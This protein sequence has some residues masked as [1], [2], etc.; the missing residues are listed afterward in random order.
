MSFT[1]GGKRPS[2]FPGLRLLID[3]QEPAMPDTRNRDL[4]VWG[5]HGDY[6]LGSFLGPRPFELK[7]AIVQ[8]NP[9]FLQDMV[10]QLTAFLVDGRGRPKTMDLVFDSE[11]GR[12]YRVRYS[13]SMGI[14]RL[15]G[16]GR[17]SL[18]M[19]AYDPFAYLVEDSDEIDV[20]SEIMVEET[21]TVDATYVYTITSSQTVDVDNFG[22]QNARPTIKL[23]GNFANLTITNGTKVLG[24][25]PAVTAGTLIINL[26]KYTAT[27]NGV[28]ALETITGNLLE[29]D[30]ELGVN[31]IAIA[32]SAG[33][34]FTATFTFK[35]KFI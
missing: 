19:V 15:F 2:D 16:L 25:A 33:M 22:T 4:T 8:R 7:V 18:P 20:D 29:F 27:L 12:F 31:Q 30:F 11:P 26:E 35:P 21:A 24:R 23:V 5:R 28:N 3:T 34:N 9:Y 10:R 14:D 6:D 13:G 32:A 1:L 17:F